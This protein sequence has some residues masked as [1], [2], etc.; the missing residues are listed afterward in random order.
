MRDDLLI[1]RAARWLRRLQPGSHAERLEFCRWMKQ[2]PEHVRAVL[3]ASAWQEE[4]DRPPPAAAHRGVPTFIARTRLT[5]HNAASADVSRPP[6]P[7]DAS[8]D[9]QQ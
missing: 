7:K 4:A 1:Y 9:R 3:L 5:V 8:R 6:L 2:S